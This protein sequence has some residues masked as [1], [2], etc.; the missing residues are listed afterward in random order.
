MARPLR[1]EFP[2][3]FYHATSRGNE[4]GMIFNT[5]RDNEKFLGYVED[6]CKRFKFVIHSYCLMS[7][8]YHF[9]IETPLGNLSRSMQYI[10]SSYT[11][12]YNVKWGRAGHLFQG[13]Y[14][15][16]L[17]DADSYIQQLSR[18]VHLNPV[19]AKMVKS[20]EEY[21]WSSYACYVSAKKSPNFLN[22][23][24]TLHFFDN[25]KM[26]YQKF[27]EEGLVKITENPFKEMKAGFILGDDEF[28]NRIKDKY[29]KNRE[30]T[31]DLPELRAL[32][33]NNI[34]SELIINM[35]EEQRYLNDKEKIKFKIYFLRK[36]TSITL[37]E[38]SDILASYKTISISAISQMFERLDRKR[39][40]DS[41]L[42][43][44]IKQ[45]ELKI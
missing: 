7:N 24:F 29:L 6:A 3:A 31:R 33:K 2:G 5:D 4:K 12:Y 18:Y 28:A 41:R 40:E 21:K 43:K 15:A 1:V 26:E 37:Q 22:T 20:P 8:H 30:E 42:D 32:N 13:R 19:R 23:E 27:V 25:K 9:I 38:I 34:S 36:Y 17:I 39:K 35:I 11:S 14:K 44:R 16:I 10:N 45:I